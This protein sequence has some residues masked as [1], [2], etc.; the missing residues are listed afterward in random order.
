MSSIGT[1]PMPG[2]PT[3]SFR[4]EHVEVRRHLTQVAKRAAALPST[5]PAEQPAAMSEVVA[6]FE[7][8]LAPHVQWEEHVLYALVDEKVA[9]EHRPRF[10]AS[11]RHEHVIIG[12]WIAMLRDEVASPDADV[13]AFVRHTDRLLGLVLAHF[14][15]EEE[16]LLPILDRTMTRADLA[17]MVGAHPH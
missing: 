6:A 12:R 16:V 3:D 14:E 9:T 4:R 15:C 13:A 10:T 17:R 5:A 11:L 1:A 7:R 2:R 8:H